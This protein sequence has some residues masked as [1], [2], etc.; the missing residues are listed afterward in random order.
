MPQRILES[1]HRAG[2]LGVNE[3]STE[4][5]PPTIL[6]CDYPILYPETGALADTAQL[7]RNNPVWFD[8]T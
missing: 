6:T 7:L 2:H 5:L 3:C 1:P 8:V 4:T